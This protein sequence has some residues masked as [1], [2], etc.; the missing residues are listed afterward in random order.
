MGWSG[1]VCPQHFKNE[2]HPWVGGNKG[3]LTKDRPEPKCEAASGASYLLGLR[4]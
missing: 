3:R 1:L 2:F 4:N